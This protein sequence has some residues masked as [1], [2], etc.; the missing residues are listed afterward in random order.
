L[1]I[2]ILNRIRQLAEETNQPDKI[3]KVNEL[4]KLESGRHT[5]KITRIQSAPAAPGTGQNK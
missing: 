1:R 5:K 3:K 2:A 4:I